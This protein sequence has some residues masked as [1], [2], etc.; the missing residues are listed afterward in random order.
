MLT[1]LQKTV[2]R[3]TRY[4]HNHCMMKLL[5]SIKGR[6]SPKT[7]PPLQWLELRKVLWQWKMAQEQDCKR[8]P[9]PTL[10]N[11]HWPYALPFQFSGLSKTQ[12]D[13]LPLLLY[14]RLL[15]SQSSFFALYITIGTYPQL[16]GVIECREWLVGRAGI[17]IT[18]IVDAKTGK[19]QNPCGLTQWK[20]LEANQLE[21]GA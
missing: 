5:N 7:L 8:T 15:S 20:M 12:E 1:P 14:Y 11:G 19:L 21:M 13:N 10:E 2:L 16:E 4:K 18:V 9:H 17:W 3:G 6:L